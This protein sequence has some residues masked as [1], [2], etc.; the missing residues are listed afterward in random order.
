[1]MHA[2]AL[3]GNEALPRNGRAWIKRRARRLVRAFQIT[4]REAVANAVIDWT[5]FCPEVHFVTV[6]KTP[7]THTQHA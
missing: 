7:T 4:R 5:D 1:M 3:P 6:T 2:P